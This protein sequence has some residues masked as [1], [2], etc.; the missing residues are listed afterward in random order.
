M[1]ILTID[2]CHQLF[3]AAKIAMTL[4]KSQPR[5]QPAAG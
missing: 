1:D 2:E 5:S 4:L 3:E